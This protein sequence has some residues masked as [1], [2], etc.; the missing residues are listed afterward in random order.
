MPDP[1]PTSAAMLAVWCGAWNGGRRI[2]QVVPDT[3]GG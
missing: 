3:G 2:S 1:P